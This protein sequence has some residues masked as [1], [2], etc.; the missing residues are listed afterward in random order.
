LNKTGGD[1]DA[2]VVFLKTSEE[3]DCDPNTKCVFTWTSFIPEVTS[4]N[5]IFDD[6]TNQWQLKVTGTSLTGDTSSVELYI[7]DVKQIATSVSSTEAVFTISD[8]TSQTLNSQ[9]LF[10]DVGIPESHSLVEA[11]FSLTP[12]LVSVLPNSGSVGGS[13]ITA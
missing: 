11:S 9:K 10:F 3:A 4:V 7:S 8:V 1:E 5:L 6:S 13:L 12:K 2:M